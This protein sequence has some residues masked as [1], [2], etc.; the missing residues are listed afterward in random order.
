MAKHSRLEV[1]L[2]LGEHS[3]RLLVMSLCLQHGCSKHLHGCIVGVVL[4]EILGQLQSSFGLARHLLGKG[5]GGG[6]VGGI[7]F[8]GNGGQDLVALA[9]GN[10]GTELEHASREL[11][12]G[13]E[14]G[15]LEVDYVLVLAGVEGIVD[16][17]ELWKGGEQVAWDC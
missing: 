5:L 9:K 6:Q 17:E 4:C 13:G 14:G 15:G 10:L 1:T 8:A 16:V 2:V 3:D 12:L 11:V 7:L